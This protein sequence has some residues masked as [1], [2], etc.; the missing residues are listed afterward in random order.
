MTTRSGKNY[1]AMSDREETA[2]HTAGDQEAATGVSRGTPLPSREPVSVEEMLRVMIEDRK[3]RE[4]E[5]ADERLRQ[6]EE[7]ER[8]MAE[9]WEQVQMLQRL[10]TER[11]TITPTRTRG[12]GDSARLTRLSDS[13]DI[14]AY[15]TTFERMM[16]AFKVDR[17]RWP[18]KLA[19]QLTGKAQQAYAASVSTKQETTMQ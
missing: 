16:E 4:E 12:E 8:C 3:R 10:V 15:L 6:R 11:A 5:I 2:V 7:N 19:P 13:D 17:A 18:Y 1:T 9:M 14:E